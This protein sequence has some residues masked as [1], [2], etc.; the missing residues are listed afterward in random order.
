MIKKLINIF[1]CAIIMIINL[2]FLNIP[3]VSAGTNDSNI[4]HYWLPGYF[5]QKNNDGKYSQ[6]AYIYAN[7][8]IAYCVEPGIPLENGTF[9]SSSDF[10]IAN[11]S[12]QTRQKIELIAAFGYNL[13]NHRYDTYYAATQELIWRELGVSSV[14]WH[15]EMHGGETFDLTRQKNDIM[16]SV[17]NYYKNP[18]FYTGNTIKINAGE[19]TLT[20]TNG[21]L[22][23]YEVVGTT[24]DSATISNN[25]LH[26]Y[27]AT[28]KNARVVIRYKGLTTGTSL[29]YYANEQQTV[30]TLKIADPKTI[31][32]D[33]EV[34]GGSLEIQ[35]LDKD[36]KV[37]IAQ[38]E[39]TLTG[40]K[41]ELLDENRSH[42]TYLTTDQNGKYKTD[43]ILI[44][45]KKYILKEVEPSKGY[46][47]DTNEYEVIA[48][49]NG[50]EVKLDVLEKV[51][52]SKIAITKVYANDKTGI[53]TPEK[54]ITFEIYNNK[55]EV[56][57]TI[58]TDKDGYSEIILP[59]G[60]YRF[61]QVNATAG[62]EK[63]E[64]FNVT[65]DENSDKVIRYTLSNSIIKAKIRVIK[66]D[67]ETGKPIIYSHSKFKIKNLDTNEYVKQ[68][69]TYPK[70]E[71]LDTFETNDDG[72]FLLPQPLESNTNGYLLE[73]VENP[74]G[75]VK[76]EEGLVFFINENS[77]FEQ[78]DTLGLILNIN[79]KNNAIKGQVRI[80]KTAEKIEFKDFKFYY[81][82][83]DA[84]NIKFRLYANDDIVGQDGTEH[85]KLG[86][87][88]EEL[89]TDSNGYAESD[90][91]QLGKYCIQ[92]IETYDTHVLNDNPICFELNEEENKEIV[93][94]NI[95]IENKLKKGKVEIL[96]TDAKT[97][98]VIPNVHFEIVD[99]DN[100]QVIF[101]GLTGDDG[102]IVIDD[103]YLGNFSIRELESA[104][105]YKLNEE[106][107]YFTISENEQ[108]IRINLTN[109]K[110]IEVPKT[111]SNSYFI[112]LPISTL[113]LS[114]ILL[115]FVSNKNR[116]RG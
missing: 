78:D 17:N 39:A 74:K 101:D 32:F 10:N 3:K 54:N 25:Q 112:L 109:E 75:Y 29:V 44:P 9:S 28:G 22:D 15:T 56:F 94:E 38:G 88:V 116:K 83:F 53:L 59:Y 57:K 49:E 66:I 46:E 34:L 61:H 72:E 82:Y 24:A 33:F 115:L 43:K 40:A 67:G 92:E 55:N 58:T 52:E 103:L 89:V 96:K 105:G 8:D 63:V 95:N 37:N 100:N 98:E 5:S 85:Y 41:Y 47:L 14:T 111:S 26:I 81:E 19:V 76:N 114:L 36:T 69:F 106:K 12:P 110:I 45:N 42:V 64:D 86:E 4:I 71:T 113:V 91:L 50:L 20:D 87:E 84:E 16:N 51:I 65:V 13:T 48:T 102:K 99:E 104:D 2:G 60:T 1:L 7:G 79:F 107:T 31:I 6:L 80:N 35:K 21:I 18:S 90:K 73:E 11:I 93:Y 77:E 108:V 27:N 70:V 62:H 23:N 68:V 30:A 97:G